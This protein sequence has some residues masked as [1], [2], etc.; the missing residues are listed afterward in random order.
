MGMDITLR[1]LDENGKF[2]TENI[3]DGRDREWFNNM[4]G[5][6]I[7]DEAYGYLPKGYG[8]LNFFPNEWLKMEQDR[9][10]FDF[11]YISVKEY[12]DWYIKYNPSFQAGWVK[13][14][15]EFL[16]KYR[17]YT[18]EYG[19]DLYHE[20]DTEDIIEDMV[21]V[22]FNVKYDNSTWLYN[23]LEENNIPNNAWIVYCFDC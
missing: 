21:W 6:Y 3:Y 14:Y 9:D 4:S 23:Y 22:E 18:P 10:Y 16:M 15:T 7:T 8:T 13:R 19:V 11:S 20:L 5:K 17:D 2:L 1:L 12:R